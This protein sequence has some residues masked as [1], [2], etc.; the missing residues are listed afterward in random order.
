[1]TDNNGIDRTEQYSDSQRTRRY[2]QDENRTEEYRSESGLKTDRT[3]AHNIGIGDNIILNDTDYRVVDIISGEALTSEAI[4]YKIKDK[5]N[6]TFALKL[7][8]SFQNPHD[9]PNSEALNRIQKIKNPDILKL[10]DYG[11]GEKKFRRTFCFE[12]SR[13][14]AGGDLLSPGTTGFEK[15]YTLKFITKKVIPQIQKGIVTLHKHKIFHGDLKPQNVFFLDK[16]KTNL[17]IGDYGSA[18][19]YEQGSEKRLSHTTLAKGTSFYLSPEQARGIISE[20]NDYYSFGM[21]LLHL[22]YPEKVNQTTLRKIIERQFAKKPIIDFK[23]GPGRLNDLIAGLTLQDIDTRWGKVE[24]ERWIKGEKVK[25]EYTRTDTT[26]DVIP[27]K[28]GR[29]TIITVEDLIECLE[30]DSDWYELLIEDDLG[31]TLLLNWI[32]NVQDL[33]KKKTFDGMVRYYLDEEEEYRASY[34]KEAIIRYF[35]PARPILIEDIEYNFFS[36]SDV[37]GLTEKYLLHLD[38]LWKKESKNAMGFYLFQLEFAL[39]RLT[40]AASGELKSNILAILDR[41][42]SVLNLRP[43]KRFND[44]KTKFQKN[45]NNE[46]LISLFYAFNKERTFKDSE[47]RELSDIHDIALFFAKNKKLFNQEQFVLER[48]SFLENNKLKQ[49]TPSNYADFLFRILNDHID[50]DIRLAECVQESGRY[51]ITYSVNKSLNTFFKQKGI[52]PSITGVEKGHA[53]ATEHDLIEP[54]D[55]YLELSSNPVRPGY[56]FI[57]KWQ[58]LKKDASESDWIGIFKKGASDSDYLAYKYTKG[59]TRGSMKFSGRRK[60]A[61]EVRY[62][63]GESSKTLLKSGFTSSKKA[64]RITIDEQRDQIKE[65]HYSVFIEEN[66]NDT[67]IKNFWTEVNKKHKFPEAAVST[68][69][70]SEFRKA[71]LPELDRHRSDLKKA[72]NQ[73]KIDNIRTILKPFFVFPFAPL[74]L[75][76][77]VFMIGTVIFNLFPRNVIFEDHVAAAASLL[78]WLK[79]LDNNIAIPDVHSAILRGSITL[80]FL[81]IVYIVYFMSLIPGFLFLFLFETDSDFRYA[82]IKRNI[83]PLGYAGAILSCF[84]LF[85]VTIVG[86]YNVPI[87]YPIIHIPIVLYFS[88]QLI[89]NY[90]NAMFGLQRKLDAE[91]IVQIKVK[92]YDIK[93]FSIV[94]AVLLTAVFLLLLGFAVSSA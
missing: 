6:K 33:K 48:K 18:K 3:H 34:I 21:I 78:A 57:V 91:Y 66:D 26:Y 22:L 49:L 5:K 80:K 24:V 74:P 75:F 45:I 29:T 1:M 88:I 85:P 43:K 63:N 8:Y 77:I 12:I 32:S 47:N 54:G 72:A 58:I 83:I 35:D 16:G 60:G 93:V 30:N 15:K 2:T 52:D 89:I 7:Y 39:R 71:V 41:I 68:Y 90:F 13:F 56:V 27:I 44:F 73:A 28:L 31:Y 42:S 55:K 61:Y 11:T 87:L 69:T 92:Q 40:T 4:V 10:Y 84:V 14:A 20:K 79:Q 65:H 70:Q 59:K 38:N 9:K 86:F 51:A 62:I 23:S 36:D 67:V 64:K 94:P 76:V 46:N 50:V 82:F 25:V 17:V 37:L 81:F 53:H 19:T